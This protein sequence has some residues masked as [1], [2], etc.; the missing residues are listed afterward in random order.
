MNKLKI[1]LLIVGALLILIVTFFA[2]SFLGAYQSYMRDSI[3]RGF[4]SA[5]DLKMLRQGDIEKLIA[6]K[7]MI[8]DADILMA[9]ESEKTGFTWVLFPFIQDNQK[10]LNAIATY[11]IQHPSTSKSKPG[12]DE[13]QF[14]LANKEL[15]EKYGIGAIQKNDN[16]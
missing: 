7:E 15:Q 1:T 8:L 3:F 11:R 16:S 12:D 13:Y 6:G 5:S 9:M 2:G 10:F 4:H 14:V